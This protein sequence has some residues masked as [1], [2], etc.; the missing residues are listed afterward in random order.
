MELNPWGSFEVKDYKKLMKNF[1]IDKIEPSKIPEKHHFFNRGIIFG[2]KDF[3]KVASAIKN[4]KPWAMMTGLMP[5]GKFHFG[6]KMVADEMI[7]FQ[8][9]GAECYIA[10]ADI[11]SNL[12]RGI[13]LEEARKTA[14]EEYLLNYIALG[15]KPKKTKFYFQSQGSTDYMN[16][17]K[18]VSK[19]TT[20]NELKSIYG[21]ITPDKMVS[22]FTQV[23]DILHPQLKENGGPKPVV[24]P[25]G[26]DQLP[27]ISL[28]R[29]IANRMKFIPPA[30]TFHKLMPGLKGGK[31]SSSDPGS[32]IF[33]T[34][35]PKEIKKRVNKYAF[36]GGRQTLE[37]HRKKG[38]NP[39]IDISYQWLTYLEES[40]KKLKQTYDDYKAGKLLSGEMKGLLIEKLSKFVEKHKVNREKARKQVDK[41]LK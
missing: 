26:V 4:K 5:S 11:E 25:V 36:S 27:H 32:A 22:A 8:K 21:D 29:D 9:L 34:D 38:G 2:H 3:G 31:L 39:D 10:V 37:E 15:L 12:T 16:L 33:L 28:T 23:A 40:D 41:F 19:K 6:H 20:Y 17:S 14:V 30:A 24:V 7:Y 18:F 35:T 13:S 1:G